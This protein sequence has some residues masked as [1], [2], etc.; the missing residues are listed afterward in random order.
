MPKNF[1][2]RI[3][4]NLKRHEKRN[5]ELMQCAMNMPLDVRIQFRSIR[6]ETVHNLGRI[7]TAAYVRVAREPR[8]SPRIEAIA[9]QVAAEFGVCV[10]H[11]YSRRREQHVAWPR[12]VAMKLMRDLTDST[13]ESIGLQFSF[14]HTT[15]LHAI[16]R[17]QN[18]MDTEPETKRRIERLAERLQ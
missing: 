15:V 4:E 10:S 5:L 14:H 1:Q 6:S 7:I 8:P 13:V 9:E 11:L 12:Q 18:R 2:L 17:V 3:C 16:H